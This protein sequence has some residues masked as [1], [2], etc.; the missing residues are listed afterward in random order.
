MGLNIKIKWLLILCVL[1]VAVVLPRFDRRDVFGVHKISSAGEGTLGDAHYYLNHIRFYR[2]EGGVE[3][4]RSPYS[5]RPFPIALAAPLPFSPMTSLNL[6]NLV[7]MLISLI[8]L[9]RILKHLNFSP[10]TCFLGA[11]L[12]I[13]SFPTFYYSTIG[14]VDPLLIM[15]LIVG[16][17][18]I[19]RRQDAA[20]IL[21]SILSIGI[22]EKFVLI[23]P[24]WLFYDLW[25]H[26]RKF[27]PAFF[28]VVLTGLF[29]VAGMKVIRYVTPSPEYGWYINWEAVWGNL[30]RPRAWFSFLLTWGLLGLLICIYFLRFFKTSFK[31]KSILVFW[32][33]I[34]S[35]L[36]VWIYGFITCYADGRYVWICYPF[37][38]PLFCLYFERYGKESSRI[39]RILASL[40]D[41]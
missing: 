36:S 41:R 4:L 22:N 38:V 5:F 8:Y 33:G 13:F 19:V 31:D 30:I 34:A 28:K 6:V 3:L 16:V 7:A 12:Y 15:A 32:V 25:M 14:Y 20:F 21:L 40:M 24:F 29:F 27:V 39:K 10:G 1:L 17:D 37:M 9:L 26:K 23:F 35:G 2:G 18:F 11:L